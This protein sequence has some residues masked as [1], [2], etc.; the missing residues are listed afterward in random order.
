MTEKEVKSL[1]KCVSNMRLLQIQTK[2]YVADS[3]WYFLKH[4]GCSIG[5]ERFIQLCL[6]KYEKKEQKIER[7]VIRRRKA[8]ADVPVDS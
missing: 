1:A 6:A 7:E 4:V 2:R 5:E 8:K 3:L